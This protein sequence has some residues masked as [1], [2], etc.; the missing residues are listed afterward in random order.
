MDKGSNVGHETARSEWRFWGLPSIQTGG[1]RDF[2]LFRL[3]VLR[4]SLYSDWRFW[5]LPSIQ[6]GGFRDFPLFRLEVLG[7]SLYS[8]WRF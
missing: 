6:T 7:T 5:G 1:F 2:P 8:D 3:E 4:T